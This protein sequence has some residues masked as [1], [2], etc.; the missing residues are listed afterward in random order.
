MNE[1][2]PFLNYLNMMKIT[3]LCWPGFAKVSANHA[4]L[5][6]ANTRS[7]NHYLQIPLS[8]PTFL[9]NEKHSVKS[10]VDNNTVCIN[11]LSSWPCFIV[12]AFLFG[13]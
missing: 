12:S 10:V 13:A 6:F 2:R 9:L 8:K 3:L 1:G 5:Y 4:R 7:K 11:D